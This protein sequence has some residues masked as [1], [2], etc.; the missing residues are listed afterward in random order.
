[1]NRYPER[2]KVNN[3]ELKES[4]VDEHLEFPIDPGFISSPPRLNAQVMMRRLEETMPWRSNRP[5][6]QER[7]L[8]AK[9]DVEF[10]L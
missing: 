10:I 7:R 4:I 5:G 2:P 6:E 9:V 8:A 3:P 1:M